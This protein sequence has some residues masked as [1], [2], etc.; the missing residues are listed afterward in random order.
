LRSTFSLGKSV[1]AF[2]RVQFWSGYR[3]FA[4]WTRLRSLLSV[5]A[6]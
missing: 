6:R 5:F 2:E 3:V 1:I 4:M